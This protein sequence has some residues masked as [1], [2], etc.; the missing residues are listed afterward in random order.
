MKSF[1]ALLAFA[2]GV[3]VTFALLT[4]VFFHGQIR[5]AVTPADYLHYAVGIL[6]TSDTSDMVPETD[7]VQLW[8]SL[9]VLVVWVYIVYVAVNHIS[10]I[11]F[12][13]LG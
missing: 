11:K 9:Y 7:A 5:N 3:C 13:R 10:N 12:G 4:Y 1:L 6:T 8:T 2:L